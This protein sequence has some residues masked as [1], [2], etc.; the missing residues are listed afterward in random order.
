MCQIWPNV[1]FHAGEESLLEK[2]ERDLVLE[3]GKVGSA[4]RG[5]FQAKGPSP[6]E[7]HKLFPG[8]WVDYQPRQHKGGVAQGNLER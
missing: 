2:P 6:E 8:Q 7:K 3:V 1:L 5:T 4:E